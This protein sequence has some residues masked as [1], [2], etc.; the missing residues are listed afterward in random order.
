VRDQEGP[1]RKQIIDEINVNHPP[2]TY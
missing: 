1:W 2:V